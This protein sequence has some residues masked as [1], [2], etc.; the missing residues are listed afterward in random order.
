LLLF[1]T[2]ASE[3]G[4][5]CSDVAA[6]GGAKHSSS[7]NKSLLA[8]RQYGHKVDSDQK[9]LQFAFWDIFL[10]SRGCAEDRFDCY[11]LALSVAGGRKRGKRQDV[12]GR[13][14]KLK[15]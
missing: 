5:K 14:A 1:A 3:Q 10:G 8:D 4:K 9:L 12:A 7:D 11:I 2:G 15:M 6:V 13:G